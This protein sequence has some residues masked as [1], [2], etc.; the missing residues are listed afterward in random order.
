MST[1]G[2]KLK[3]QSFD[4]HGDRLD[5]GTRFERRI[6]RSEKDMEYNGYSPDD[7]ANAK[8][9]QIA[10]LIY[11]GNDVENLHDILPDSIKP[12]EMQRLCGIRNDAAE[13]RNS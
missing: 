11:A 12:K 13:A 1:T 4:V 8:K 7:V 10:P 9:A 6:E 2:T 3:I 5:M